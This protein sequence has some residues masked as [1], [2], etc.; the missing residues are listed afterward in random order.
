MNKSKRRPQW[1]VD[2]IGDEREKT[3]MV[4]RRY[5]RYTAT[6]EETERRR[7]RLVTTISTLGEKI[8]NGHSTILTFK[9]KDQSK[10]RAGPWPQKTPDNQDTTMH[11]NQVRKRNKDK[12]DKQYLAAEAENDGVE[13]DVTA[14]AY[15]RKTN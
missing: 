6:K 14:I 9:R 3:T 13:D 1:T 11:E 5:W 8:H 2:D 10:L 4:N 7:I 15:K 12:Y